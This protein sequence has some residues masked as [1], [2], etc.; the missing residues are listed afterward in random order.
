MGRQC[1]GASGGSRGFS[2]E[3]HQ[4]EPQVRLMKT[5]QHQSFLV[6]VPRGEFGEPVEVIK[7]M[8]LHFLH[9]V[10]ELLVTIRKT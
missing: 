7:K 4:N 5:W 10:V 8:D 6:P 3:V 2:S 9:P 1:S